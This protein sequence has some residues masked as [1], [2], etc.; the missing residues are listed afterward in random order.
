[1]INRPK[2]VFIQTDVEEIFTWI[3]LPFL[4]PFTSKLHFSKI[5]KKYLLVT[6]VGVMRL[7]DRVT[8]DVNELYMIEINGACIL[9]V[10]QLTPCQNSCRSK[11]QGRIDDIIRSGG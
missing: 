10:S 4:L 1:M 5:D 8:R 7:D 9:R 2:S 3:I 6:S 11:F